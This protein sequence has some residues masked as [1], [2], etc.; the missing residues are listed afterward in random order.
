MLEISV[1]FIQK[2][3]TIWHSPWPSLLNFYFLP[4][5]QYQTIWCYLESTTIFQ[6]SLLN[7]RTHRS[8]GHQY[9]LTSTCLP[10]HFSSL[11]SHSLR[12]Y[13]DIFFAAFIIS[14]LNIIKYN[15]NIALSFS[16]SLPPCFLSWKF[17]PC[18]SH[19]PLDVMIIWV[20]KTWWTSSLYEI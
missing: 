2:D 11:F 13:F 10:S 1:C 4:H 6:C 8:N 17:L 3:G 16:L 9:H 14:H 15:P 20:W 12:N 18:Y 5:L 19:T 7:V